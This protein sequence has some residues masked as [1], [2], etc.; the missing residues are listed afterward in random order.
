MGPAPGI[1]AA[2]GPAGHPSP[3]PCQEPDD[4][5]VELRGALNTVLMGVL[6]RLE[7]SHAGD[8]SAITAAFRRSVA[9]GEAYA[10]GGHSAS[11]LIQAYRGLRERLA[12][13]LPANMP[14]DEPWAREWRQRLDR[15]VDNFLKVALQAFE[16][17]RVADWERVAHVDG[18]TRVYNR[19]YFERRFLDEIR[20]AE[21]YQRP[22]TVMVADTGG[23]EAGNGHAADSPR[24][25]LARLSGRALESVLRDVDL[26]THR[27]EH[28]LVALLPDTTLRG[29]RVAAERA[30]HVARAEAAT[31]GLDPATRALSIGLATYPDHGNDPW[32]V[33][34]AADHAL[35]RAQ[36]TGCGV[37]LA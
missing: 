19:G 36:H 12:R 20:R 11:S 22:I 10:S 14:V 6:A 31:F 34:A 37:A 35:Y 32:S 25:R 15:A 13:L 8:P 17:Q 18:A 3:P 24:E 23:A 1:V 16:R 26:V 4:A 27:P 2:T 28:E 9:L 5:R 29:G 21:R 33:L 30:L 7:A